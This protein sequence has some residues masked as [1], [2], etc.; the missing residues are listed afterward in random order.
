[1]TKYLISY[2]ITFTPK[3]DESFHSPVALTGEI[4]V[5]DEAYLEEGDLVSNTD[6]AE[7]WFGERYADEDVCDYVN[8]SEVPF[9]A[10]GFDTDLKI[11]SADALEDD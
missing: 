3:D 8:C 5:P 4:T 10:D 7:E 1:M 6:D 2:E 11:L 9:I